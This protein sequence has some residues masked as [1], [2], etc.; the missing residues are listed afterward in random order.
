ML[1]VAQWERILGDSAHPFLLSPVAVYLIKLHELIELC[2]NES[3]CPIRSWGSYQGYT[4]GK[5]V[6]PRGTYLVVPEINYSP[7]LISLCQY[8]R[9]FS[10]FIS[11]TREYISVFKCGILHLFAA[12]VSGTGKQYTEYY[13]EL[14]RVELLCVVVDLPLK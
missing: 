12:R 13:P 8:L 6:F 14:Y 11:C 7:N 4:S 9:S 5:N 1:S 2:S 3:H 10:L